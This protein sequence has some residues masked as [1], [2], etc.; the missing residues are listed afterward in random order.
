MPRLKLVEKL[1][2]G[3]EPAVPGIVHSL[4]DA[5]IRI[6]ASGDIEQMLI[7]FRIL[8]HGLGFALNRKHYRASAFL[9]LFHQLGGVAPKAGERTDVFRD[10]EHGIPL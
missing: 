6:G 5:L 9:E 3:A 10:V 8:N 7:G 4:P 2:Y 1:P